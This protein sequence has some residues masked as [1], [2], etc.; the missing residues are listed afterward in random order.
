MPPT[1]ITFLI[2]DLLLGGSPLML[3]DLASGLQASGSGGVGSDFDVSIIS[4]KPLPLNNRSAFP[5]SEFRI[6]N[7][8]F[9]PTSPHSEFTTLNSEFKFKIASLNLSSPLGFPRALPR[10]IRLL[11][12]TSPHILYSILIH[13]NLLGTLA[14]PFLKNRPKFIQSIHTLQPRPRWHWTLQGLLAPRADALIVP[15]QPIL[16]RIAL[17]GH[18]KKG[19][20]IPNGIDVDRFANASPIPP[21]ERP[22]PAGARVLGYVGRFDPVKNLD[23]LIH[24][25]HLLNTPDSTQNTLQNDENTLQNDAK[26][27]Q[28]ASKRMQNRAVLSPNETQIDP[29]DAPFHLALVG[30]G[31]DES[32]LRA[33]ST[34][35]HLDPFVHFVGPTTTPDRWYKCLDCMV[36]PSSV[37]GFGLTIVEALAAGIPVIAPKTPVTSSLWTPG[38]PG[39]LLE[40]PTKLSLANS[41][42]EVT[43][44]SQ[45][46]ISAVDHVRTH[47]STQRMV[48]AHAEILKNF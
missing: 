29:A 37:E 8:E 14:L 22:W 3:R 46:S 12:Q 36:L 43:S 7:S 40:S 24:T 25:L 4:L 45:S 33:L 34:S 27:L 30:Y 32:R 17:H 42:T 16:D 28:I 10:L 31:P 41:I 48:Q 39:Q 18:F 23:L 38:L 1:R 47:F 44:H 13:A 11:N 21:A 20:V 15:S 2:T 35:L 9:T 5:S 6:Q 19:I 26:A